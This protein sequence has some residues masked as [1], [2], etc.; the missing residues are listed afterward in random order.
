MSKYRP[1]EFSRRL[2]GHCLRYR[3]QLE[4][5]DPSVAVSPMWPHWTDGLFPPI[6]AQAEAIVADNNIRLH[7]HV[8]ALNSSMAFAFNLFLP[9]RKADGLARSLEPAVGLLE[10]DDVVLEWVPP[11]H[12]LGELEG[13]VPKKDEAATGIDAVIWAHRPTGEKL[14]I[15]IEVKLTERGFSSCGGHGSRY[16]T[17][18]DVCESAPT[19]LADPNACYL[20]RPRGK[21]RDRRYWDIFA[22]AHG[23]MRQAFP[24]AEGV[25]PFEGD[26]QQPMR[27]HALALALEAEGTVDEAWLVLVHHDDNPDVVPPWDSYR[28]RARNSSRITKRPASAIIAACES[29]RAEWAAYLRERYDL[30]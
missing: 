7:S 23:S 14:A 10:I 3:A 5:G 6:R 9:L 4:H 21:K 22:N 13:D 27:Q 20:T 28:Q 24:S 26:H 18:T 12:L 17:R 30:Q 16:N 8:A 2:L 1:S 11:G 29:T 19:F 15:L 25:C